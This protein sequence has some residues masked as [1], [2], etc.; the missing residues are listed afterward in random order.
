M[1]IGK[2]IRLC[3]ATV[4]LFKRELNAPKPLI[5]F[6]SVGNLPKFGRSNEVRVLKELSI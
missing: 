5:A 3:F 4:K 1:I 6:S 2:L